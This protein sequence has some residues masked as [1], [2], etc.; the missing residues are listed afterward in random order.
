MYARK[1]RRGN[2]SVGMRKEHLRPR[3]RPQGSQISSRSLIGGSG[4]Y[5]PTG[6]I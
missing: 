1:Y 4:Q 6:A 2:V 3:P 5:K